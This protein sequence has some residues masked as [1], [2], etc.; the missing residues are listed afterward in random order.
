MSQDDT[1]RFGEWG[2]PKTANAACRRRAFEEVGG[3]RENIRAAEDADLTYRL[4][5]AGWRLERREG[6]AVVH[7]SRQTVGGFATQKL[8][9]GAGGAWL[10]RHYPGSA[11]AR[12][13]SGLTWW[14]VRHA[15]TGL[16]AAVRARDRDK[17]ISSLLDPLELLAHEFGRSLPN[18]RPLTARTILRQ[19]RNLREPRDSERLLEAGPP[20]PGL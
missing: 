4:R 20:R 2:F 10:N 6:A 19:L 18:E 7:R 5:A 12:R 16:V 1:F 15:T 17:A 11:P 13:R 3:F 14:A 8:C 9:H